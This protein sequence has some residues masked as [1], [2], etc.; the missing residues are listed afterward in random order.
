MSL[1]KL[2]KRAPLILA[3]LMVS[4]TIVNC[5]G[6]ARPLE[7]A[8]EAS[9]L[10]LL[11]L[12]I[13]PPPR[14]IPPL[15]VGSDDQVKFSLSG[16]DSAGNTL[17]LSAE[18]R[19]WSVIPYEGAMA[20]ISEDG[21]FVAESPGTV[22]VGVRVGGVSATYTVQISDAELE[23]ISAIEG[24]DELRGCDPSEYSAVGVFSDGFPRVL[25]DA[26]W[27]VGPDDIARG[28]STINGIFEVIALNPGTATLT[29]SVGDISGSKALVVGTDLQSIGITPTLINVRV[30]DTKSL[31]A[32]GNYEPSAPATR[33]ITESVDWRIVAG[34]SF[35]TLSNAGSS[36]GQLTGI[37][38]GSI[39]VEAG[40]GFI[41]QTA[42]AL[43]T[44][45]GANLSFDQDSPFRISLAGQEQ[46]LNVS[47]GSRYSDDSKV[48][49]SAEWSVTDGAQFLSVN[50]TGTDKGVLTPVAVGEATVQATFNDES[51]S[52]TVQVY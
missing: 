36:K 2:I 31:V 52:I 22:E 13:L 4:L 10:N 44:A 30:G 7:E 3:A 38:P 16:Q 5:S 9:N 21:V 17:D 40:C 28:G 33:V 50:N 48:T 45:A 19:R 46:Q 49:D 26:V 37:S 47:T 23:Q 20:R 32:T 11:S 25:T 8:V 34:E 43:V 42:V 27:I 14:T 24:P 1:L 39:T 12:E 15:Y 35:A 51:I 41:Q 18:D 29:A 6:D